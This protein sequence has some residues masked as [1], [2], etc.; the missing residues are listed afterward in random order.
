[1]TSRPLAVTHGN[2][3]IAT[4][5]VR[6]SPAPT[7]PI[8]RNKSYNSSIARSILFFTPVDFTKVQFRSLSAAVQAVN[9]FQMQQAVGREGAASPG[10]THFSPQQMSTWDWMVHSSLPWALTFVYRK[11]SSRSAYQP[12]SSP[13]W[14]TP[15]TSTFQHL[16]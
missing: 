11:L 8:C 16:V 10:P 1:M 7:P 12:S 9:A 2:D 5:Y 13:H 14:S 4:R 6:A 15:S 3:P